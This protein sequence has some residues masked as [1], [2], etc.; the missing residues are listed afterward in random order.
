MIIQLPDRREW[1]NRL[2]NQTLLTRVQEIPTTDLGRQKPKLG[3]EFCME[4]SAAV[5]RLQL[6][7]LCNTLGTR[8]RLVAQF[9]QGTKPAI[10]A[11]C[12][13]SRSSS[14]EDWQLHFSPPAKWSGYYTL[15]IYPLPLPLLPFLSFTSF[16]SL[17]DMFSLPRQAAFLR[18]EANSISFSHT[19]QAQICG[20]A[21]LPC[22]N[23]PND[24][25]YHS[26]LT[27]H[28]VV[29]HPHS[30]YNSPDEFREIQKQA[31]IKYFG[32]WFSWAWIRNC[33]WN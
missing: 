28:A 26:L 24:A 19:C 2:W 12:F 23:C 18:K 1:D 30:S 11:Q 33:S 20:E 14:T 5:L 8:T 6:F 29:W 21:P 10:T 16:P 17:Q 32:K 3:M 15:H 31:S 13:G 22:N 27:L 7:G 4:T 9:T 25:I